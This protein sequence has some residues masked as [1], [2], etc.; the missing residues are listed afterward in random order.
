MNRAGTL[1]K[2]SKRAFRVLPPYGSKHLDWYLD[3]KNLAQDQKYYIE[4]AVPMLSHTYG[5]YEF[6]HSMNFIGQ[7]KE[8]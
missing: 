2:R 4:H 7:K 1:W 8:A 6:Y 3:P 5:V